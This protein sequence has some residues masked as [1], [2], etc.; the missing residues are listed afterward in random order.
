MGETTGIDSEKN[1]GINPASTII[2][3]DKSS[4]DT[5]DSIAQVSYNDNNRNMK[6]S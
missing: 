4:S 3:L 6:R 2:V 5:T 1:G